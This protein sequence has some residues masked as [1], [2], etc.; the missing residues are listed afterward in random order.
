[1]LS[2]SSSFG[3]HKNTARKYGF[4]V[5]VLNAFS[6][7]ILVIVYLYASAIP[8]YNH[9]KW[10]P[11]IEFADS[12]SPP[13]LAFFTAPSWFNASSPTYPARC[14]CMS[15]G[16]NHPCSQQAFAGTR[17]ELSLNGDNAWG[18]VLNSTTLP[19]DTGDV[20]TSINIEIGMDCKYPVPASA[21]P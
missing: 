17:T 7:F 8:Q 19:G 14:S 3:T 20:M 10:E 4:W 16:L 13:S 1:M 12:L 6:C 21:P 18:Y 2:G 11:G 15:T 9:P 5:N